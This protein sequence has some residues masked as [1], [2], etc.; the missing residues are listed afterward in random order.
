M[1][2][3]VNLR[4][5]GDTHN[6]KVPDPEE[7]QTTFTFCFCHS[8]PMPIV[9]PP[10]RVTTKVAETETTFTHKRRLGIA[11]KSVSSYPACV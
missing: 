3:K 5:K 9:D 2:H 1:I 8:S 7:I 10:P 6:L 4:E 11:H